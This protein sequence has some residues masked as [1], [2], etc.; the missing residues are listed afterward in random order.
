MRL[1]E[2]RLQ[3]YGQLHTS[4]LQQ[5]L[6]GWN[7]IASSASACPVCLSTAQIRVANLYHKVVLPSFRNYIK[8]NDTIQT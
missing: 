6:G 7:F 5:T 2:V 3:H 1:Y 4:P 8:M